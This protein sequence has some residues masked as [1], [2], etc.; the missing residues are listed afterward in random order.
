MNLYALEMSE[1]SCDAA[2]RNIRGLHRDIAASYEAERVLW[3]WIGR[4]CFVQ[5]ER[6]HPP[7][8]MVELNCS[9]LPDIGAGEPVRV[10]SVVCPTVSVSRGAGKRGKRRPLPSDRWSDW[11]AR[12]LAGAVD[13]DSCTVDLLRVAR[14]YKPGTTATV[15]QCTAIATG[16]VT[17]AG[18]LDGLRLAGI[19]TGKAYGCGLTIMEGLL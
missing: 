10:L 15:K 12:K 11:Y 3:A 5:A 7:V 16:T 14:A 2:G 9:P 17:D 4:S 6:G 8:G 18:A 19:G 1:R 13:V